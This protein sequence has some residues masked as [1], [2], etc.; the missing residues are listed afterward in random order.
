MASSLYLTT[1]LIVTDI[2]PSVKHGGGE[3]AQ[4]IAAIGGTYADEG[5]SLRRCYCELVIDLYIDIFQYIW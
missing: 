2:F 4:D 1:V 3:Q 5:G